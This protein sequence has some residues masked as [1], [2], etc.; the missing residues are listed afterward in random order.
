MPH[1]TRTIATHDQIAAAYHVIA[2][3]EHRAWLE[4]SMR[5]FY[6]RLPVSS[7]LTTPAR[8]PSVLVAG[9]GEGRDSRYLTGLGARALSFDLSDGMLALARAA[10]P[11]GT[12]LHADLRHLPAAL[13]SNPTDPCYGELKS[14]VMLRIFCFS[15][16]G[17]V[18]FLAAW[19]P[20]NGGGLSSKRFLSESGPAIPGLIL[21]SARGG[22]SAS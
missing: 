11:A 4:D 15:E 13:S 10:D 18:F 3:P 16:I 14:S 19:L 1:T 5:E 20:A 12:Y 8:N 22:A 6:K 17:G 9:C 2:T 7:P 21:L